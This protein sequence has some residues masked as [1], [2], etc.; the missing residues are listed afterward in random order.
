VEIKIRMNVHISEHQKTLFE[1]QLV[2]ERKKELNL[3]KTRNG[4]I[5]SGK[6]VQATGKGVTV[7]LGNGKKYLFT[8]YSNYYIK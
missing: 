5:N 4:L 1:T 7:R 2:V 8:N 6:R 3:I